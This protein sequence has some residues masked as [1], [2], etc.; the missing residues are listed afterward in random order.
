MR[1]SLK[2][3]DCGQ[4]SLVFDWERNGFVC[5]VYNGFIP[6]EDYPDLWHWVQ[7]I[8]GALFKA[9]SC[10]IGVDVSAMREFSEYLE[11]GH[12]RGTQ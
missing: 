9:L 1:H 8:L 3:P 4:Y 11:L 6:I 10:I 2:C 7:D 12:N 5:A